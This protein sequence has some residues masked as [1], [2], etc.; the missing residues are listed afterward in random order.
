MPH[1]YKSATG[2]RK[3]KEELNKVELEET[4]DFEATGKS[5]QKPKLTLRSTNIAGKWYLNC[6]PISGGAR[7]LS[8]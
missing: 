8:L 2:Q 4:R 6:T 7:E 3:T 5:E 1:F